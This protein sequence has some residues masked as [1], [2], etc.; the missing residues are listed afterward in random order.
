MIQKAKITVLGIDDEL[1]NDETSIYTTEIKS[2]YFDVPPERDPA[3]PLEAIVIDGVS[4][5]M[6]DVNFETRKNTKRY[7]FNMNT[8]FNNLKLSS[9]AKIVIESICIPNVMSESFT[10]SK[11]VNNIVLKMKG[12]NNTCIWDSST[13]GRGS[14]I[15]FACPILLNSQGFGATAGVNAVQPDLTTQPYKIRLN[16][17]NNGYLFINPSPNYLYNYPISD[18]F[19]RNGI[20]EFE[21]VYDVG[22]CWK[23]VNVANQY[24]YVPQTLDFD[25][26][27]NDLEAFMISMIVMDEEDEDTIYNDKSMLNKINKLLIDKYN[28]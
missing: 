7:R 6:E 23:N 25:T 24:T 5:G 1:K 9:K 20:L 22:N 16:S 10:Q 2:S 19:L 26:D 27:I 11:C 12:I 28:K 21:L 4:F 3:N 14:S 17:D 18:E 13:K 15:I 8:Y